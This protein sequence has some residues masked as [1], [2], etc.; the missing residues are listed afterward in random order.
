MNKLIAVLK[1]NL[2]MLIG[3]VLGAAGGYLYWLKIGCSSGTCPITSSPVASA[4]WGAVM[5]GLVLSMFQKEKG[6]EGKQ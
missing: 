6:K 3:G 2:L 5:G 4:V 1:H